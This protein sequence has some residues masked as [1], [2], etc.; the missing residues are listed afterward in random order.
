MSQHQHAPLPLEKL[1]VC[2]SRSS[3]S[4]KCCSI[5]IPVRRFQTPAELLKA[6]PT[7]TG[8][9]EEGLTITY[10]S[11]GSRPDRDS[12]SVTRK[13]PARLGPEKISIARLPVTGS[14]LF[15]REDDIA[16]LNG[17]WANEDVNV[18]TIVAWAGV[19]KS[20]LV[21][22]WL[23]GM[24]AQH[25]RSAELVFGW[26][27]YR[28][29]TSGGTSSA[30]EFLDAALSL[31]WRSRSTDRNGV[32]EGRK[33]G[34]ARS[35]IVEPYW[36]WMAWSRS[37]IRLVHKKDACVSLLSRRFCASLLPSIRGFA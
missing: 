29:G 15:G 30:D 34:E 5:K 19:G 21:N 33:I 20:T 8:A 10:Q 37:K 17:A 6:L 27:F 25:Y 16:F 24:A 13:S 26:S 32:G 9:I 7:I 2:R 12:Y 28:Q 35:H 36:F 23:R 22:H 11:L 3:A 4:S 18:V 31:V 1:K 14:D